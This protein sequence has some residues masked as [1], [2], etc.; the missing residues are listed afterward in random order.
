MMLH[1]DLGYIEKRKY[2]EIKGQSGSEK[3]IPCLRYVCRFDKFFR[4]VA[5]HLHASIFMKA[6]AQPSLSGNEK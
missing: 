4:T 3:A 6:P 5:S 1:T 2:I